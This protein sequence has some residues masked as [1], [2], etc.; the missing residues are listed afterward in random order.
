MTDHD[1]ID[2]TYEIVMVAYRSRPLVEAL[3]GRL[4][5]GVPVAIVD[6]AH[7]ADGI[8]ELAASRPVTRYLDGPGRGFA[9]AANLA[10]TGSSRETIMLVNPD[11]SPTVTQLDELASEL[12]RDPGLVAVSA[13]TAGPDGRVEIGVGGWEPT[14]GRAIVHAVGAH[15]VFP[16][17][18]LWAKPV[19]GEDIELDWLSGACMAL[20][21]SA[22]RELGGFDERY[23]VYNDDVALGRSIREAG[24]RQ[25]LRSDIVVPHL[26][27]GSGESRTR[28]VQQRAASMIQ[29][30]R[31]HNQSRTVN[32]IRL[33]LTLGYAGR[34]LVGRARGHA[35]THQE[36][37]AYIRGL[38]VG[39]PQMGG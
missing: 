11:S 16:R 3:L 8:A 39:A 25:K 2:Y 29:Y 37:A 18:G 28:M 7:G 31:H 6:N 35:N 23:F 9:A 24:F 4:P 38:W 21:R 32:G 36:H 30:V 1:D 26:G 20:R 15:K 34:Y 5:T 10:V 17:R 19:P 14:V 27:G 33:A 12:D 13:I 22:F